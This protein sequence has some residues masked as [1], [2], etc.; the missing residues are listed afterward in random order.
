MKHNLGKYADF[1]RRPLV[2]RAPEAM[3]LSVLIWANAAIWAL[4]GVL[5]WVA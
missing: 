4:L 5:T 3:P 2:A 1:R